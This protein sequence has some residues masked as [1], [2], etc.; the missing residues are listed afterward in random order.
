MSI[1]PNVGAISRIL[2]RLT[3]TQTFLSF[4][5]GA[6]RVLGSVPRIG[7]RLREL[8]RRTKYGLKH[9]ILPSN[10]FE[11]FGFKYYGP[12]DSHDIPVLV[13]TLRQLRHIDRPVILHVLSRK[14]KGCPFAESNPAK[15]HGFSPFVRETGDKI[16]SAPAA[17][18]YTQAFGEAMLELAGSDERVLA[19]TAAMAEGTGLIEFSRRFPERFFDVGIAEPH[20]VTFAAGL[21]ADGMRPVVAI[22]STF[23]QRAFDQIVHDVGLQKLPVIFALDRA[24]LVGEDGPTHHGVLDLSYLRLVPGMVVMAPSDENELRRMLATALAHEAG[25]IALRY[26]RG[27]ALGLADRAPLEALPLGKARIARAGGPDVQIWAL[28][29]ML[30]PALAAAQILA[31]QGCEARVFDSRFAAPLDEEA[32]RRSAGEAV[33]LVSVE[34]NCPVGGFGEAVAA[35]LRESCGEAPELLAIALPAAYAPQGSRQGLLAGFGMD[36]PGIA[37][38]IAQA[39]A[40]PAAGARRASV[41]RP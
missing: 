16:E 9:M 7:R 39:L 41:R 35:F 24:G 11:D 3:S 31:E 18:T 10:F 30:Q 1:S 25:P 6:W 5:G 15:Y 27:A 2:T 38:R 32:M 22:Y 36:G 4:E 17:V 19:I 37:G 26:P 13:Q 14:G 23:L 8:A 33:L 28:G 40:K 12:I 21:A 34:E 20:A 29:S